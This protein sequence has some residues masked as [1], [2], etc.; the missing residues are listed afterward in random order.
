MKTTRKTAGKTA[1]GKSSKTATD[2]PRVQRWRRHAE[3]RIAELRKGKYA[4]LALLDACAEIEGLAP[5]EL[6]VAALKRKRGGGQTVESYATPRDGDAESLFH[7]W[8]DTLG[9]REPERRRNANERE[10]VEFAIRGFTE[11]P[12]LDAAQF[13]ACA[14]SFLRMFYREGDC[15]LHP[16]V[17]RLVADALARCG[18]ATASAAHAQTAPSVEVPSAVFIKLQAGARMLGYAWDEFLADLWRGELEALLDYARGETG[19]AEIPLTRQERAALARLEAAA[20]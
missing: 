4:G 12:F 16:A 10:V 3:T 18:A 14:R 17:D 9:E 8:T 6:V 5:A 19:K 7:A 2:T 15:G 20:V 13:A 1:T 11:V